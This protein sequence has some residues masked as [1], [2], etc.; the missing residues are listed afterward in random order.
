MRGTTLAAASG[1]AHRTLRRAGLAG[2]L[3]ALVVTSGLLAVPAAAVTGGTPAD[4]YGFAAHIQVGTTVRGCSGALVDPEWV[5]TSAS[6]FAEAGQA[7]PAG[8][9]ALPTTVTVGRPDLRSTTGGQVRSVVQVLPHPGRDL[10]LAKLAQPVIDIAPVALATTAPAVGETLQVAGYGRTAT[11]WVPDRLHGGA[12]TVQAVGGS[13]IDLAG[14]AGAPV[15]ICKGDAGGPALRPR[16]TGVE[17]VGLHAASGQAG[18]FGAPDGA[19]STAVE[20]RLDDV[21]GWVRQ[22]VRGGTFV[23]LPTSAAALDTR[24][25]TG[26]TAGA[27][28]AGSTT[29]FRVAGVGGVPA[30]GVT[31]VLVDVT[32]IT[33]TAGLFLTVFPEGTTRPAALS[34]V[35]ATASQIISNAAVVNV[36]ASG[37]LSVYTSG[38]GVHMTVDVQGYYTGAADAGGGYVPVTPTR[39]VDTRSG[40]GGSSVTIPS[41]GSR[42]FPIAGGVVPVGASTAF[43][44]LIATGATAQGWVGTIPPGG[45]N[46][47]VMD[48]VPGTT[49]HGAAVRLGTDGRATFT[50]N[51]GSPIHLVMTATGYFTGSPATGAGLRTLTARRVIDTRS[52]TAPLP[53]N[54]TV[55]VSTG[56]P[57]GATAVVNLIVV[58]NTAGGYLHAWPLGGTEP[59]TSLSNYPPTADLARGGLAKVQVGTSGKIRL[60]NV[61]TGTTHLVVDLEGWYAPN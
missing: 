59:G 17:L 49:S 4:G 15:G 16:G 8:P 33:T 53:A 54:G 19:S 30:T 58:G 37:R 29:S 14:S 46:R 41:G 5:A 51:S 25:G 11:A 40:L 7:V 9:P 38:G 24:N 50:N 57:P 21:A 35:N 3:T 61:S 55:D 32:A 20:T 18:C 1:G 36:P 28:A 27:R 31:A 52:G 48:Y 42:S 47:S 39:V 22:A 23:R 43:I 6:C 13:T 12:L 44:D 34:T 45:T 2:A 60:R 56:L 26:A 10:A